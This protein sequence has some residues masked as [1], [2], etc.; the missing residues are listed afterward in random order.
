VKPAFLIL[1]AI[2]LVSL[3]GCSGAKTSALEQQVADL[4]AKNAALEAR[5][6]QLETQVQAITASLP[7]DNSAAPE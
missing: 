4:Q 1:A 2:G 3:A 7:E 6:T 5:V